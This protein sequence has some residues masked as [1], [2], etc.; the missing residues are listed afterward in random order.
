VQD[1]NASMNLT[2]DE[3]RERARLLAVEAYDVTLDLTAGAT[4][5]GSTTVARFT[6]T[7]PGSSTFIDLVAPAVHEV[8][9]NGAKLPVDEVFDGARIRLDGLAADNELRVVADCAYMRTGEGLHRFVDP[10]DGEVYLYS[11]FEVADS[12]RMFTVFE[13]PDLKARFTFTVTAPDHWQVVSN[14][15]TPEPQ[16]AGQGAATWRFAPTPRISSYITALVAGPYHV[17][18]GEHVLRDG[19]TVPMGVFCRASLAEFLDADAVLEVTKQG[20]DFF[21]ELFDYPYP[22]DK[23]DQLFV[24]EFNA[25]AMENAGAVT[26]LEDYVFRSKVP[27]AVVERRAETILHELAHMWFGDLVTMRWWD[28]LWLNESFATYASVLCQSEVTRWPSAWTTFANAEKTWAYRQ[29]QL[30]STHPIAADIRDLEDVEVNFDGITYA[31]GAS[32][33]KQLVAWVGR[34][35]FFDGIRRYFTAHEWGNTTLT[36][37]FTQLSETSG[38]DLQAWARDWLE[39]AGVNTLRPSF[40]VDDD[41]RFTSFAVLQEAPEQWP[42]LRPHRLAIGLYDRT[43]ERLVRRERIEIDVRGARTDVP[44]LV[45]TARPDLVLVNDD[46][47]AY[48]KVRLDE[49]SL[50]TLLDGISDFQDSLPR[51]LC[52]AAAWDMTRDAEMAPRDYLRLVLDGVGRETDSSVIR[53]LLAQANSVV[54]LYVA[55]DHR[56]EA[57]RQ[58]ADGMEALMRAAAPGSD[59]QLQF[60]RAFAS[61]ARTPEHLSTV[62]GLLDGSQRLEG[63]AVDTDLR[64]H[65]LHSLVAAGRAGDADIDAELTR[66]RTATGERHAAAARAAR[67]T[68]EAKAQAWAAVVDRDDLPNALLTATIGGFSHP[69]HGEH[70]RPFVD[71]YFEAISRVWATRT[72]ETAQSIVVGLYPT[73]LADPELVERS[74]AW[75]AANPAAVPALRR[76]VLESRDGVARALRAQARDA[77]AAAGS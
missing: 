38:R 50:T 29:D 6:C 58:L 41:D 77:E 68:A 72:N 76:L 48:A 57:R 59:A 37:L 63:L 20:F 39:T 75:L 52:W 19:R 15:P 28:D 32:V 17:E 45:G 2:R 64:W 51:T 22:F 40:E 65:L 18:R 43:D 47:L 71:R 73:V 60:V 33:L 35:N 36:D 53:T 54:A 55:P 14:S 56:D 62:S 42:T 69:A 46:D 44:Q 13:Q 4:T 10:V 24:P 12:R 30:P 25:G 3:A 8:V 34:D 7:E 49:Q 61:S 67:P 70:I 21:E 23:Y 11:Q 74:D 16:A 1:I 26:F 66:D 5:F 27:D 31:K 9:L